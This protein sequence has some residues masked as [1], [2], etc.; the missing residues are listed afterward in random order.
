MDMK[1]LILFLSTGLF[2][3][4]SAFAQT[5]YDNFAPEQSIKPMIELPATQFR[6]ENINTE[7]GIRY[8]EFDKNTLSLTLLDENEN[9]IKIIVF[10]PNEK[11]FLTMDPHAENYPS[12]SPYAFCMNN[13]ICFI[14]PDGRDV[15]EINEQGEVTN[16][17]KD[18]KQDAFYMVAKDA[19]G[20]YQRTYTTDAKGNKNYNSISFEYG[21]VESQRSISYSPDGVTKGTYDVYQVRGDDNGTALFEFLGDNVT[22]SPSMV[23][24]GQAKTGI[25]GDKGLNFITTGHA[26]GREPGGSYLLTGQL[27]NGYTVRELNHTH[28]ISTSVIGDIPYKTQV[29]DFYRSR[30]MRVPNFNIYHVPTR[31]TIPY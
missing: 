22:G 15:W 7:G 16:R 24:I 29:S 25:E 10:N 14:D 4:S 12:V 18:K 20:N 1:K 3:A 6:I 30:G 9:V 11:K 21:T 8:A 5:P 31:S 2:V 26:R 19:D 23:E 17:I 27:F 13:P 28:P